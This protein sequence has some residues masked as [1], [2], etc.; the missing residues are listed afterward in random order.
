M[1]S[2]QSAHGMLA[3]KKSLTVE[4]VMEYLTNVD[5]FRCISVPPTKPKGNEVYL[6]KANDAGKEGIVKSHL[7]HF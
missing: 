3:I 5:K 1:E 6:Y 2:E 4:E 7:D